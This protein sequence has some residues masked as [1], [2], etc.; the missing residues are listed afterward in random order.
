MDPHPRLFHFLT[1]L[2][3][4]YEPK[5]KENPWHFCAVESFVLNLILIFNGGEME[6]FIIVFFSSTILYSTALY[7]VVAE[8]YMYKLPLSF[9]LPGN[10]DF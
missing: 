8:W 1:R 10:P 6:V 7:P 2:S 9:Q 5:R 4:Y 3:C